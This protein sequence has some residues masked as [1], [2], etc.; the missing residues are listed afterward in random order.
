[1][2]MPCSAAYKLHRRVLPRLVLEKSVSYVRTSDR[3]PG[4]SPGLGAPKD[5]W[6]LGIVPAGLDL[7]CSIRLFVLFC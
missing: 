4:P 3:N 5:D 2:Y 6:I 7:G 1:M